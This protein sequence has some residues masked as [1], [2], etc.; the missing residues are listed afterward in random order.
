MSIRAGE[1]SLETSTFKQLINAPQTPMSTNTSR[2][3]RV[4][5]QLI[6]KLHRRDTSRECTFPPCK[7]VLITD[8]LYT[9]HC[10]IVLDVVER[11]AIIKQTAKRIEFSFDLNKSDNVSR[12]G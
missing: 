1:E 5:T 11:S 10:L 2:L 9:I 12:K 7:C 6:N 4:S 8:T 3:S